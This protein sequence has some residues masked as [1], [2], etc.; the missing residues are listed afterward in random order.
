MALTKLDPNVIGQ[1]STGA[2]KI[3]SAGGSVSI[4]SI[5]NVRIANSSAN[6]VT[7]AANG[8]FTFGGNTTNFYGNVGFNGVTSFFGNTVS[9]TDATSDLGAPSSRWRNIYISGYITRTAL[10]GTDPMHAGTSAA[11]IKALTGTTVDG[12]Y[13]LKPTGGSGQPFQAYCIMSR[14]GGGWVKALQ[15]NSAVGM[16]TAEFVNYNGQW[17]SQEINLCAGKIA[18]ADWNA[19]N[20]TN[21]FLFRV[22]GT[23]DPL[24]NAGAGTGKLTYSGSL[25]PFGTDLDPT[26]NYT[27]SLDMT[28]DG[29]YEYSCTYTNDARGRCNSTTNYW[30]S[31]HNYNGTFNGSAPPNSAGVPQCWTI[32]TDRVVTNLHWMSGTSVGS[33]GNLALGSG[34]DTS[35]AIY[36][37]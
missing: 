2:G 3:T 19:L 5:G 36:I 15:Y 27:L 24:L 17:C 10:D 22:K 28:S 31:D 33:G 30:I 32:G 18:A 13:W 35:F 16:T 11:A 37:K 8:S 26:S 1:D 6:S 23:A 4:D 25:T 34:A 7:V 21:S 29:S 14:D 12:M 20:T 9:G